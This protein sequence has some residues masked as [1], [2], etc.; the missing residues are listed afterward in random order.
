M[1][2]NQT[3]A[4]MSA[5]KK[6]YPQTIDPSDY[7]DIDWQ[8]RPLVIRQANQRSSNGNAPVYVYLF[9]WQS[10]VSDG[11]YKAFHCMDLPFVFN[12]VSRCEEMTGGGPAAY[13]LADKV[14]EAWIRFARSGNPN[15]QRLPA[16]PA[17]TLAN[18]A[19][20]IFDN[21][22]QVKAHFDQ[23]LLSITTGH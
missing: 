2:G 5:V 10:P 17:Y 22:C 6:A 20:M 1:L 3:T 7:V 16:W 8:F 19:T 9:A 18:G 11:A 12:N 13:R 23:E 14:S 21:E 15:H 4:Y